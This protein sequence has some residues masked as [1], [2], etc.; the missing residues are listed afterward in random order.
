MAKMGTRFCSAL[1]FLIFLSRGAGEKSAGPRGDAHVAAS[2]SGIRIELVKRLVRRPRPVASEG[3]RGRNYEFAG[4]V[5]D[6]RR[7]ALAESADL[8]L[9]DYFNNQCVTHLLTI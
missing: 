3:S 5:N 8:E 1:A 7:R 2:A 6:T 9:T 4:A